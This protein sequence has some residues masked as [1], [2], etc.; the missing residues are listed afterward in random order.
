MMIPK[1]NTKLIDNPV[2]GTFIVTIRAFEIF[3]GMGIEK[4]QSAQSICPDNRAR[5]L[6][7]RRPRC[8]ERQKQASIHW[9]PL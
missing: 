4:A 5:R 7:P 6:R 9:P 8:G 3:A 1:K 2:D